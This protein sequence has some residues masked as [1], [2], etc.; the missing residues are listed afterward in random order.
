MLDID[1]SQLNTLNLSL[2]HHMIPSSFNN[3]NPSHNNH[4]GQGMPNLLTKEVEFDKNILFKKDPNLID[5]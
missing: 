2:G 5:Y 4:G 1:L 3:T